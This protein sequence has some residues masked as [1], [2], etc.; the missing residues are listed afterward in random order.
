MT[1]NG[2]LVV[3]S[4]RA[5]VSAV[6]LAE[7]IECNINFPITYDEFSAGSFRGANCSPLWIDDVDELIRYLA[8]RRG[9]YIGGVSLTTMRHR[10]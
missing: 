7:W 10:T 4:R 2:Y 6:T 1:D 5:A 9:A 8:E 3:R